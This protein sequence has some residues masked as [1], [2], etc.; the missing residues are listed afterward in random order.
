M[1]SIIIY[2]IRVHTYI[3]LPRRQFKTMKKSP[4]ELAVRVQQLRDRAGM[5]QSGLSIASDVPQS[6]I[7]RMEKGAIKDVT[8]INALRLSKQLNT[9]VEYLLSGVG[10]QWKDDG[11]N[12]E[13]VPSVDLVKAATSMRDKKDIPSLIKVMDSHVKQCNE[14]LNLL[15]ILWEDN[16]RSIYEVET[17]AVDE[18]SSFYEWDKARDGWEGQIPTLVELSNNDRKPAPSPSS[19][20]S[21][22]FLYFF[23]FIQGSICIYS[24]KSKVISNHVE[25]IIRDMASIASI[26]ITYMDDQA[27]RDNQLLS[28]K[29]TM[30]RLEYGL[31]S[32]GIIVSVFESDGNLSYC[33]D[34]DFLCEMRGAYEEQVSLNRIVSG[35]VLDR[36]LSQPPPSP[37]SVLLNLGGE[38]IEGTL[39][40]LG[41]DDSTFG[42]FALVI[43]KG[44]KGRLLEY[45]EMK[46]RE[47]TLNAILSVNGSF[48]M[49]GN[50]K[51]KS[52]QINEQALRLS[53]AVE[54]YLLNTT[55]DHMTVV[56]GLRRVGGIISMPYDMEKNRG[57]SIPISE[58]PIL[59]SMVEDPMIQILEPG[60]FQ[61]IEEPLLSTLFSDISKV[62]VIIPLEVDGVL[63][64]IFF[65]QYETS[66]KEYA[67]S[68]ID[69]LRVYFDHCSLLMD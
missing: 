27:S 58:S 37:S 53:G 54:G 34:R 68:G 14:S 45:Q 48:R 23:P 32:A 6:T 42:S 8:G 57:Y 19:G 10:P 69:H 63:R 44:N 2:Y 24:R 60:E 55:G 17:G 22:N 3:N 13:I 35:D 33:S 65:S 59:S 11:E 4:S 15:V 41:L 1:E 66:E 67:L 64:G 29:K 62:H 12:R 43:D 16:G 7:S 51:A 5:T 28:I 49:G 30:E 39:H 47:D 61:S 25:I 21:I 56:N 9:S 36:M 20:S 40:S 50:D 46:N 18:I 26:A 38:K 31:V 52:N